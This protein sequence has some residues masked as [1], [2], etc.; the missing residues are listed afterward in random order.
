VFLA[1]HV[2]DW[3]ALKERFHLYTKNLM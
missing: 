2:I 3:I 1:E